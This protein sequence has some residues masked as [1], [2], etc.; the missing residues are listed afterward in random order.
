MMADDSEELYP[1]ESLRKRKQVG[2]AEKEYSLNRIFR[3]TE[4]VDLPSVHVDVNLFDLS[5]QELIKIFGTF[6]IIHSSLPL[7]V[8]IRLPSLK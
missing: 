5:F 2:T 4:K 1:Q 3:K 7:H 8:M 6:D